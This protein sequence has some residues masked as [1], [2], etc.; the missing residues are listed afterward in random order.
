MRKLK[1]S[2]HSTGN[3]LL[4]KL[5]VILSSDFMWIVGVG[6]KDGYSDPMGR[7]TK[8][9]ILQLSISKVKDV[10]ALQ[11]YVIDGE[12]TREGAERIG[13]ELL[14]DGVVQ[15]F[16]FDRF[17]GDGKHVRSLDGRRNGWAIEVFFRPG[18]MD[19]VGLSVAK[20]IE[21]IGIRDVKSVRTGTTYIIDGKLDENEVKTICEKCLANPL[22][23]TYRYQ[24]L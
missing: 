18:V 2:M 9:D 6:Y 11:T 21:V 14:A 22:I 16:N 5:I 24:R 12:I 10:K 17:D 19:P 4:T 15:F 3:F 13:R 23:Q 7:N 20:A 8:S 1:K